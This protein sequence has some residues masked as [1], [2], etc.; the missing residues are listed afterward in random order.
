MGYN[1]PERMALHERAA[2]RRSVDG[3]AVARGFDD[4]AQL[5]SMCAAAL[6]HEPVGY[7]KWLSLPDGTREQML[8]LCPKLKAL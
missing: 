2:L 3:S 8:D 1:D 6:L 4:G 7:Q 5:F